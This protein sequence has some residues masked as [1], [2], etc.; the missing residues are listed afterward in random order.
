M[1]RITPRISNKAIDLIDGAADERSPARIGRALFEALRPYA[2]GAIYAR[3]YVAGDEEQVYSRISPPGWESLY[4]ARR[5]QNVNYLTREVRRRAEPFRW[6][7]IRLIHPGERELAGALADFGFTDG[8]AVP[9]HGPYGYIGVVSL[10][11]ERLGGVDPAEIRAIELAS[12]VLHNR[13]RGLSTTAAAAAP[14]LSGRERDCLG[15]VAMGKSDH[16][17]A[18]ILGV[19]HTTVV[20]HV[21]NARRKLGVKTRA[22]AVATAMIAGI[23]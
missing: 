9:C 12:L 3:G 5:F 11:F 20:S 19:S 6:T 4:A 15:F 10:A 21:G 17:I 16:D 22:Q 2:V 7:Q 23:L 14:S 8:V 18:D 1:R 13:M